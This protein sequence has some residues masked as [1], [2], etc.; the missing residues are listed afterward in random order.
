MTNG[1]K[2]KFS[3]DMMRMLSIGIEF[4]L[5]FAM[6]VGLGIW[7]DRRFNTVVVFTMVGMVIGFGAAVYRLVTA[8]RQY[9]RHRDEDSPPKT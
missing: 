2:M 5:V 1:N 6:F 9:Q 7:L 8:S 3:P 4:V